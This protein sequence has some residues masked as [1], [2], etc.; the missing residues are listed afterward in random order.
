[1]YDKIIKDY[2]F[3]MPVVIFFFTLCIN[4]LFLHAFRDDLYQRGSYYPETPRDLAYSFYANN[5]ITSYKARTAY[6]EGKVQ[7]QKILNEQ[8]PVIPMWEAPAYALLMGSLWKLT[9]SL[10]YYDIL[11][12]QMVLFALSCVLLYA[13][14]LLMNVNQIHAL[15]M[16][17]CV[18]L[19]LPLLFVNSNPVRDVFCFYGVAALLYS[20][21][22]LFYKHDQNYW[23]FLMSGVWIALCQWM[24]QTVFGSLLM[25]SLFVIP[26]AY[27]YCR[28]RFSAI[29]KG[30]LV[31]WLCNIIC[32]WLPYSVYNKAL[33]GRYFAGQTG[34]LLLDSMG[35]TPPNR[36]NSQCRD[37]YNG[38]Y[39]DGCVTEYTIRRF[40]LDRNIFISGTPALDDKM[41]DA[42][43]EWFW[44]DPIFWFKGLVW[45]IKKLLFLD[46]TWSTTHGWNWQFYNTFTS[47]TDRLK[48]TYSFGWF[49]L[50][51]FLFRRWHVRIVMLL[52]YMGAFLWWR[53]RSFLFLGLLFFLVGGGIA[54][55]I[56]SHP[57]HRYLTP[58]YFV[59]PLLTGYFL[60]NVV[61]Y[62]FYVV[63]KIFFSK[64]GIIV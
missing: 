39:C 4:S 42:F 52:G 31:L 34:Q 1:M 5:T 28:D 2:S 23:Y 29:I 16:V 46:M 58:F 59:F 47:Y 53:Q 30:L 9:H 15:I 63:K 6:H 56:I 48:A 13:T 12:L 14:L 17:C 20:V 11:L 43:W 44:Q 22:S 61:G 33:Y 19:F 10:S 41:K 37:V 50:F 8:Q 36:I 35:Y 40:S 7:I 54:P 21:V 27:W 51:E 3:S 57:E 62:I 45:R 49:A 55:A 60:Y 32:F 18:P 64:T 25:V 26:Y 24:R 38:L